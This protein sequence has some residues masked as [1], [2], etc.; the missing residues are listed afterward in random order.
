MAR[1]H[2]NVPG[3]HLLHLRT[4]RQSGDHADRHEFVRG[5]QQQHDVEPSHQIHREL[6]KRQHRQ[7]LGVSVCSVGGRAGQERGLFVERRSHLA[8]DVCFGQRGHA[9]ELFCVRSGGRTAGS[10]SDSSFSGGGCEQC[11]VLQPHPGFVAKCGHLGGH[12][13][14]SIETGRHTGDAG[15]GHGHGV[16][17]GPQLQPIFTEHRIAHRHADFHGQRRDQCHE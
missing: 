3:Q 11:G 9:P 13:Y 16:G 6:S 17:S 1:L 15:G 4:D 5:D 12:E 2:A 8:A 10:V 14:D 7:R